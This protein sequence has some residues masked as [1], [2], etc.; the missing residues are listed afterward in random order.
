M[1]HF[2]NRM[3]LGK[4][5]ALSTVFA[6]MALPSHA[7]ALIEK[8]RAL[9]STPPSPA[10]EFVFMEGDEKMTGKFDSGA[11]EG[12]R[13]TLYSPEFKSLSRK[14]R[15]RIAAIE[16]QDDADIW[17]ANEI[18]LISDDVERVSETETTATYKFSPT[19]APDA[20]S[21]ERKLVKASEGTLVLDKS[22]GAI[23]SINIVLPEPIKP[24]F[25]AKVNEFELNFTCKRAENGRMYKQKMGFT[26]LGNVMT[27]KLEQRVSREITA[28]M[29]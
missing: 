9:S 12:E 19:P 24:V 20:D 4:T 6:C 27:S 16:K 21:N 1:T 17:C 29:N 13:V 7:D 5:I 23:H 10:F 26:V 25:V 15:E 18:D 2:I 8:M 14:A 11:L 28:L 3:L 22:D